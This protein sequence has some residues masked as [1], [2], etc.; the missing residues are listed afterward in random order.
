MGLSN[1]LVHTLKKRLSDDV[2]D[3]LKNFIFYEEV[4]LNLSGTEKKQ[5]AGCHV[6]TYSGRR[7]IL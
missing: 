7:R 1:I 5:K 2:V 3:E 4:K 6:F